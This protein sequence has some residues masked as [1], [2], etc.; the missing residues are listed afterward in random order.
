MPDRAVR[1][2]I[3]RVTATDFTVLIEGASGPE[4][5]RPLAPRSRLESCLG[6]A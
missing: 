1:E 4:P 5:R 6:E 3:E 2:R